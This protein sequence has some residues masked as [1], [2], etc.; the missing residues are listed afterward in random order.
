M[1]ANKRGRSRPLSDLLLGAARPSRHTNRVLSTSGDSKSSLV[2]AR[3]HPTNMNK[4]ELHGR[5]LRRTLNNDNSRR[6]GCLQVSQKI[7]ELVAIT[8]IYAFGQLTKQL[9]FVGA[10][11]RVIRLEPREDGDKRLELSRKA[12]A[13]LRRDAV[14]T[15]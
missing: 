4:F 9:P 15:A 14:H 3:V 10:V 8:C 7:R 12:L 6:F 1:P 13:A 2:A 11:L 5:R